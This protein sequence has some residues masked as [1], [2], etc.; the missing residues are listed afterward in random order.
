MNNKVTIYDIAR[1]ARLSHTTVNMALRNLPHVKEATRQRVLE[2]AKAMGY[3]PNHFASTL[4]KGTSRNIAL[5]TPSS[6]NDYGFDFFH[7]MQKLMKDEGYELIVHPLLSEN[8]RQ[9]LFETILS[10]GY[11]G[12]FTWLYKYSQFSPYAAMFL[13]RRCPVVVIGTPD[14]IEMHAGLVTFDPDDVTGISKALQTLHELGHTRILHAI[15]EQ[16]LTNL[17]NQLIRSFAKQFAPSGWQSDF[18]LEPG[19]ATSTE[20]G[21]CMAERLVRE[22]PEATAVQCSNDYM[23]IGLIRGLHDLGID[24]PGQISVI[25]SDNSPLCE[26]LSPRLSSIEVGVSCAAKQMADALLEHL[27]QKEWDGLQNRFKLQS[28]FICRESI[29]PVR[30]ESFLHKTKCT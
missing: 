1:K 2:I 23:A 19:T 25:G 8:N 20:E 5:V 18:L 14:D 26:Y 16:Q 28:S 29:G 6:S 24:V 4:R 3:T 30:T 27:R 21:Y 10:G 22:R 7:V 17:Q 15:H 12:V 9:N 11:D 13:K